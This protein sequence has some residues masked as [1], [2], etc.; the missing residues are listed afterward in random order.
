MGE[1]LNLKGGEHHFSENFQFEYE[2][3]ANQASTTKQEAFPPT[4][5]AGKLILSRRL[6]L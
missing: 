6:L 2:K 4:R 5:R 1:H 3:H